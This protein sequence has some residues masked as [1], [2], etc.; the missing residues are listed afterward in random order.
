M[1]CLQLG[2]LALQAWSRLLNEQTQ[3]GMCVQGVLWR[4]TRSQRPAA[5]PAESGG[6]ECLGISLT[7][8][9]LKSKALWPGAPVHV[10]QKQRGQAQWA[11][12]EAFTQ[13]RR[14][15]SKEPSV[16]R[17]ALVLGFSAI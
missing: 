15:P 5:F 16:D 17:K 12:G 11:G 6:S 3:A 1:S 8:Q 14:G 10:V 7:H 9:R 13:E 4:E 2:P